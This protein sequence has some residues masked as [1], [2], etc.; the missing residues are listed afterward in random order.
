MVSIR[1]FYHPIHAAILWC[2]LAEHEQEILRVNLSHPGSLLKHFPQWPF[3][4]V[5]AERI[6]DAILCGELPATYLGRP[7]TSGNQADRVYWSIRHADLRVW[8]AR[9]YP[10]E[11]PAFLFPQ[12]V[13]HAECVS[14]TTH[15]ALQAEQNAS[16]RT[17]ENMRRTHAT[18]VADLEA[19]TALNR[20]LSARLDAF[21][22]PSEASES[23]QNMLVGAVLAVT[24][25]KS[26]SGKVQ[27]IYSTQAALVE[28][29][30]LRFPGVSGLSKST[31]DRRFAD[32]RRQLAQS[33][34]T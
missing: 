22:I 10:D 31:L 7:I 1:S 33:A 24:L 9:N 14:L 32:A 16:M 28:A 17:I 5:Y 2:N 20:T 8:F 11:K 3:L 12:L 15:L 29:I 18:T 4:H 34:R 23:M 30:T 13:D 26:K 19:L 6:Y 25:G 27:S 21:G